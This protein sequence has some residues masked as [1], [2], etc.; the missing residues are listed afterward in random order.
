MYQ[1]FPL[2]LRRP[3]DP[4][5]SQFWVD[6]NVGS[7]TVAM[8][9]ED[10]YMTGCGDPED[11]MWEYVAIRKDALKHWATEGKTCVCVSIILHFHF[12]STAK[13]SDLLL[14]LELAE[15][16]HNLLPNLSNDSH[17][18]SITFGSNT[19]PTRPCELVLGPPVKTQRTVAQHNSK[20]S[21]AIAPIRIKNNWQN[22]QQA[23]ASS[24]SGKG[25]GQRV[26]GGG[27]THSVQEISPIELPPNTPATVS[28]IIEL[29]ITRKDM[30]CFYNRH[31]YRSQN[32]GSIIYEP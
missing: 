29:L 31:C 23:G 26:P 4:G 21:K 10:P 9:V 11:S 16:V 3:A 13:G 32:P 27:Q 6:F 20:L 24:G 19:D 2:Q 30:V 5:I 25:G 7:Q 28:N 17:T 14:N 1:Y 18:V 22:P 15:P 12:P 8:F